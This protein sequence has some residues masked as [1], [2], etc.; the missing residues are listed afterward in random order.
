[1]NEWLADAAAALA[2]AASLDADE[3]TLDPADEER[4]LGL[5]GFAAHDSGAR[6]NAPLVCF[7][8]GRAAATGTPVET[9]V[10]AVAGPAN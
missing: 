9:L 5:A 10:A 6:L 8:A 1:V 7:L 2:A 3:L 4:L